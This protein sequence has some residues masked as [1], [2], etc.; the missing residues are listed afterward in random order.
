MARRSCAL[1]AVLA[2]LACALLAA[3]AAK[4]EARGALAMDVDLAQLL[5]AAGLASAEPKVLLGTQHAQA[6]ARQP[7]SIPPGSSGSCASRF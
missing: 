2:L 4:A 5:R 6:R 1:G 3:P 7:A